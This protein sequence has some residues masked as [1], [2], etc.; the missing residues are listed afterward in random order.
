MFEFIEKTLPFIS[1][2]ILVLL[3]SSIIFRVPITSTKIAFGM[4]CAFLFFWNIIEIMSYYSVFTIK[5]YD[6]FQIIFSC[7]SIYSLII[8]ALHF[9]FYR[10]REVLI[11]V[12]TSFIGGICFLVLVIILANPFVKELF[13][14]DIYFYDVFCL[15][16]A[17]SFTT[18]G[19][20]SFLVIII[21]KLTLSS[22]NFKKYS[23]RII[24]YSLILFVFFQI[25][26]YYKNLKIEV[27]KNIIDIHFIDLIFIS[28]FLISLFQYKFISFYPGILSLFIYGELPRLVIQR[29]A[30]SNKSGAKY[31][32]E[33]LWRIYES[34][35]WKRFLNEF[36]FSLIIEE[37]LDNAVEHGGRRWEDMIT[38]QVFESKKYL[39]FY[40]IDFGKGFEP[41]NVPN[42]LSPERKSIPTGR[43]IH[44]LKQLFIVS[45]N[46]LGN[47][48]KVRVH[49]DGSHSKLE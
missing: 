32:K 3:Y 41:S 35:N 43:G 16:L 29:I 31:L 39:D 15:L 48:I 37:T 49:K 14:T 19:L 46:F 18:F 10:R 27:L 5:N 12:F 44:I 47:E 42:P 21:Y 8:S 23:Y 30:P 2:L 40:I 45:W 9:P 17:K 25:I 1:I 38:I 13:P 34:E 7:L 20:L 24:S 11:S 4:F 28:T 26:S 22:D 6:L 36:W 33:E